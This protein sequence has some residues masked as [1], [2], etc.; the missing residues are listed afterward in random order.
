MSQ[1][2]LGSG[3]LQG[4]IAVILTMVEQTCRDVTKLGVG[5]GIGGKEAGPSCVPQVPRVFSTLAR[6]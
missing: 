6:P 5:V 4:E 3:G 2:S 1:E